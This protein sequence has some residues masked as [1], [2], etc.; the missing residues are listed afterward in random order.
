MCVIVQKKYV[1][2]MLLRAYRAAGLCVN[3]LK[4]N[5]ELNMKEMAL[6]ISGRNLIWSIYNLKIT[7]ISCN[8]WYKRLLFCTV[9]AVLQFRSAHALCDTAWLCSVMQPSQHTAL[10][11]HCVI[12]P[13]YVQLCNPHS[14]P[15]CLKCL[16]IIKQFLDITGTVDITLHN[17]S[18]FLS[19]AHTHTCN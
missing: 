11:T 1:P 6:T 9:D 18:T 3:M 8:I 15:L 10:H 12:P 14:I 17:K 2:F 7:V 13:D 5:I 16:N 4:D 19:P